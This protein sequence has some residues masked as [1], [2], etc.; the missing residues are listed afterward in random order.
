MEG[1]GGKHFLLCRKLFKTEGCEG[2]A[3]P[4]GKAVTEWL[5]LVKGNAGKARNLERSSETVSV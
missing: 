3:L 4:A 2:A 1:S 5:V